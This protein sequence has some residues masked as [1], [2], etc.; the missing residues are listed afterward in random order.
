LPKDRTFFPGFAL[1]SEGPYWVVAPNADR[2]LELMK[3]YR[4][5]RQ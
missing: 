4:E 1:K 5:P 2:F 3:Y